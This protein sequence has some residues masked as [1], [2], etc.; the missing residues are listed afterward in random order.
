[1][2]RFLP[3][4]FVAAAV[5]AS[6]ALA[7]EGPP[8]KSPAQFCK[9]ELAALGAANFKSLYS[10]GGS[11]ANAMGKCVSKHAHA[12]KVNRTNAAKACKAEMA[13]PDAEFRAAHDG[14]SFAEFYGKNKNDRNAYGKCVSSKAKTANEQQEAA[15]MKAAKA[16]KTERAA[17]RTAFVTKYG[18]KAA[19]AFGKCVSSKNKGK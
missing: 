1:M 7:A 14:K 8:G 16:C 17:N 15:T 10:P 6:A 2:K 9:S 19:S 11:G 18:G 12:A 13:M 4:I 5:T 3:F